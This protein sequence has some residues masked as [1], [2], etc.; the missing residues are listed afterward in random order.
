MAE[1]L[2]RASASAAT[3]RFPV[4]RHCRQHLLASGRVD[5]PSEQCT[6]ATR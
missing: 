5:R 6:L 3:A 4:A 2:V 1:V